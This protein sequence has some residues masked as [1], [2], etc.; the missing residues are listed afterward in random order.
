MAAVLDRNLDR[1]THP[2]AA[3][4][5][6]EVTHTYCNSVQRKLPVVGQPATDC[7]F[8]RLLAVKD[9]SAVAPLY[10]RQSD[11]PFRMP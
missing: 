5:P 11:P 9:T 2:F 4:I 7:Q 3:A 8:A 6:A 1:S 10:R